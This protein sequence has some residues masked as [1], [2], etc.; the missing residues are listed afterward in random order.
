MKRIRLVAKDL[1]GKPIEPMDGEFYSG[2]FAILNRFIEFMSR[3]R[4]TA[5]LQRGMPAISNI[6]VRPE[7]GLT[8]TCFPYTNAELHEL[9]HVLRPVILKNEPASFHNVSALLGRRFKNR[10]L[11]SYIKLQRRV[12]EDGELSLYMQITVG[13]QPLFDESLLRLWLNA[14]QY[15]SDPDKS[16]DWRNLEKSLRT[17]SAR[18]LIISQLQGK[19]TALFNLEH[20][21]ALIVAGDSI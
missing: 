5:L 10:K 6:D 21:V 18:A 14:E 2:D 11:A 17:E 3:V 12:F 16:E 9:L 19:V 8:L 7:S 15:H 4:T 20:V 13:D 1:E